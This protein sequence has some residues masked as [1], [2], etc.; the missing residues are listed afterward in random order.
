MLTVKDLIKHYPLKAGWFST[1]EEK[2]HALNGVSFSLG[3]RQTLGIVGE[4]G[5]GKSTL[6]KTILGIHKPDS[7]EIILDPP[8]TRLQY[9]FQDPYLSLNPKMQV[10]DIITEPMV[11]AGMIKR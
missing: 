5:C 8:D 6:A 11:A 1:S 4:S 2:I 3:N 9:I 10:K 7:G